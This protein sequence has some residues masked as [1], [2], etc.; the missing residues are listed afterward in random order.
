M[1]SYEEE[2]PGQE[3]T[4]APRFR[5]N[6][7]GTG[8]GERSQKR[9]MWAKNRKVWMRV[10]STEPFEFLKWVDDYQYDDVRGGWD[11]LLRDKDGNVY[12]KWVREE[13]TTKA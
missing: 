6:Y 4:E 13:D 3:P 7:D 12:E 5:S 8:I 9:R 10:S 11:Y 1:S 2:Q